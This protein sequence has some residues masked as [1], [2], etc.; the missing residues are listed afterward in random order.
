MLQVPRLALALALASSS[1]LSSGARDY[2]LFMQCDPAWGDNEMGVN[3]NGE[4]STVCG[5]GCAMSCVSMAL[6]GL[7]VPIDG[8]PANPGTLNAWLE[9][10]SGYTCIDGDCNNLVLGAPSGIDARFAL[11]SESALPSYDVIAAALAAGDTAFVAHKHICDPSCH[12]HFVLLVEA[13]GNGNFTVR[14][15][16]YPTAPVNMAQIS[17]AIMYNISAFPSAQRSALRL[18][19]QP[20][21]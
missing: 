15:P 9:S 18:G 21:A 3:G 20:R 8:R 2:Q 13:I 19:A 1:A 7:G 6:R 12:S 10:N 11:I 5:E 16:N 14:D 4:R 17:D